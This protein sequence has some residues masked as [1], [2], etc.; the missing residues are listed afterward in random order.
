MALV[1]TV[2]AWVVWRLF[3]TEY[4][5]QLRSVEGEFIAMARYIQ[6]HSMGYHWQSLWYGGYPA[7]NFYQPLAHYFVAALSTMTGSSPARAFHIAGATAYSL[8]G[9]AIYYLARQLSGRRATA[10]CGALLFSLFSPSGVL[11]PGIRGDAGGIWHARRLQVLVVYGELP[12]LTGLMLGMVGLAFLHEAIIRRRW[13]A[14]PVA[15][16]FI[17]AVVATNWPATVAL[18]IAIA[19]W[20]AAM[21]WHQLR[22]A[23]PRLAAMALMA[24]ALSLP[25]ALPSTILS[26][27]RNANVMADAPAHGPDRWASAILLACTLLLLRF[28]LLRR[29]VEFAVRFASLWAVILAWIVL[30][31]T[32]TGVAILPQALRFHIALEIPL[33]ILAAFAG[34]RVCRNRP[35][36]QWAAGIVFALF[37]CLQMA[38]YRAHAR[39]MIQKLDTA[40]TLEYS[41]ARWFDSNMHGERVLAP[42]TV[43]LWMNVFTDTP[44][45]GGCCEQSVVN[46]GNR[47]AKYITAAGFRSDIESADYSLLWLK[48]YAVRAVAIGGPRSRDAYKDF[49]FPGRFAGRLPLAWASGDDFIYRVPERVPGLARIAHLQDI[50]RHAPANG[51]DVAEIRPFVAALDDTALPAASWRWNSTDSASASATMTPDEVFAIALNYD[52]GWTASVAGRQVPVRPDGLGLIVA[53]PHCAGPCALELRW[54]PGMEPWIVGLVSLLSLLTLAA[55]TFWMRRLRASVAP[56]L[57]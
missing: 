11:V 53:E 13:G 36:M 7:T 52:A 35:K 3:F 20:C 5:N 10:F 41:E 26:T 54:S 51:I 22:E 1:F 50:V 49:A 56:G 39:S 2:N 48:L 25:F 44:Q 21:S 12:N 32:L 30:S 29:K 15:A 18:A 45:M 42:G 8:G 23:W 38:H 16:V 24:A 17:A 19:A 37:C 33:S 47:V 31:L 9:P 4:I 6:G 55:A 40:G 57:P 14:A 43:Q 27:Y 46:P 34:A 28:L